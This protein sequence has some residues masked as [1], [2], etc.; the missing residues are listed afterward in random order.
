MTPETAKSHAIGAAAGEAGMDRNQA[1]VVPKFKRVVQFRGIRAQ[2]PI[3][4]GLD[5]ESVVA[6]NDL[7]AQ[8]S[9]RAA[10]PLKF[11]CTCNVACSHC[12]IRSSNTNRHIDQRSPYAAYLGSTLSYDETP[13]SVQQG[14]KAFLREVDEELRE[15]DKE[16]AHLDK[17]VLALKNKR[18]AAQAFRD[19]HAALFPPINSL[20][21]EILLEIFSLSYNTPYQV[22]CPSAGP[23]L[24]GKVCRRWRTILWSSP[25][26]WSHFMIRDPDKGR[27]KAVAKPAV[28]GIVKRA[29]KLPLRFDVQL[30]GMLK[31]L[32]K[33]I[34]DRAAQ[35]EDV[36]FTGR[37][38]EFALLDAA[39]RFPKLK[40]LRLEMSY[41]RRRVIAKDGEKLAEVVQR[42]QHSP[43]LTK[44]TLS[45]IMY[46]SEIDPSTVKFPWSRLTHLTLS[47]RC[48]DPR[49]MLQRFFAACPNLQ[50][51]VDKG[52][53]SFGRR[54]SS[55]DATAVAHTKLSQL[56]VAETEVLMHLNCPA[57]K[58][59][60]VRTPEVHGSFHRDSLSTFI[61]RSSCTLEEAETHMYENRG[62]FLLSIASVTR[63]ILH[64][65]F[66]K[67]VIESLSAADK[68]V[69]LLPHLNVFTLRS[70]LSIR[71][72]SVATG[73]ESLADMIESRWHV[74]PETVAARLQ[75]VVISAG[76]DRTVSG[77]YDVYSFDSDESEDD[78]DYPFG[79]INAA[80]IWDE[81]NDEDAALPRFGDV[82]RPNHKK[83]IDAALDR[84]R[85][86]KAEGLDITLTS[87]TEDGEQQY[88]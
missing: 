53:S 18:I 26:T 29:G 40:T 75:R 76:S 86:L 36:G 6:F 34:V 13:E 21:T 1:K 31:S 82:P 32:M 14:V 30:R 23:W 54:T 62:D 74:G 9:A 20:P 69:I 84:L 27:H 38:S 65:A 71:D 51:F 7:S 47:L 28:D 24:L 63:F 80:T 81:A 37:V 44:L 67:V 57:L 56:E 73:L 39:Q 42:F 4:E 50:A 88:V 8:R 87:W 12:V 83:R 15:L 3:Q 48:S 66:R 72:L 78:L 10:L 19:D 70:S 85:A 22:F 52:S 61:A 41:D 5:S 45:A 60:Y 46:G 49:L 68:Q 43:K 55:S 2:Y 33:P 25:S 77:V 11:E 35:W 59:L 64:C 79:N 17:L 58:R 16:A